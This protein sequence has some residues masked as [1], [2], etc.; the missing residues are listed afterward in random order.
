M[1]Y[2][3]YELLVSYGLGSTLVW[4]GIL[5]LPFNV[6]NV[7]SSHCM[8]AT[9]GKCV[10]IE[11]NRLLVGRLAVESLCTHNCDFSGN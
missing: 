10:Y 3:L 11:G 4:L 9:V 6:D 8:T 5:L 1:D 7:A 2:F